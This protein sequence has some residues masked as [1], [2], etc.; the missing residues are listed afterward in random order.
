MIDMPTVPLPERT[1]LMDGGMGRELRR[2]G[3]D[4]TS[5]IWSA[6]A[7]IVAP[8]VVR[9]AHADFIAAGA[10][11]ITVNTYSVIRAKLAIEG[12]EDRFEELNLA[13][14]RLAAQARD[15]SGREVLIAGSLPPLR[16]SYRPDRVE[17]FA[18][19]EPLYR[20]QAEILAHPG[21]ARGRGTLV[22]HHPA[23]QAHQDRREGRAYFGGL[24]QKVVARRR[25]T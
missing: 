10:D 4:I 14:C 15:A 19:I 18:V 20:E 17:P 7:L 11:V 22:A 24:Y 12:V 8:E 16:G 21:A 23:Q 6:N 2:R 5:T 9:A 1:V 13:A 25:R 3:V